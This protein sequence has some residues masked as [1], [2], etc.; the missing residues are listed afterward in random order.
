MRALVTG[1]LGFVGRHLVAHLQA[2]G[3]DVVTLDH[4]G[5]VA[6]DITDAP[7]V[8]SAVADV[9]PDAVYHL[10]G[11][12]DVGASWRDPLRVLRVNAEGTLN[13]LE[14]CRAAGVERVLSV[15]SA[16]VYGM[17]DEAELP[18]TEASPLRPTSP[19]AASKVAADALA[20]QA[21]LGYG[22]GVVRVRPFNH[23][24]PGQS[25]AFVAPALAARI[26]RAE[27]DGRPEIPV[28][29]LSAR[30]DFTDV[31]D[32]VRAY[33]LLVERGAPGEV[34]N[35]C[36]GTD[37]AVQDLADALV[38]MAT[39]PVVLAPDPSLMR[40]VDLPVLRGDATKLA[41]ATGWRPE[42][43]LEQ[44]LADLLAD[45]RERVAAETARSTTGEA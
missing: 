43:P 44:T 27:R 20:Q 30:R 25:E 4:R 1:G 34:Y 3:D 15:A 23:L 33:R 37:V 32:V 7:A 29:N 28:G 41:T 6:V 10:A 18:L 17:V 22:L 8:R 5:D 12:A 31:R 39:R 9:A 14:G 36:H 21:H 13:V 26:A 19:Y 40:P 2:C 42:I 16:D 11:W 35:L 45:M 24:G 38:A